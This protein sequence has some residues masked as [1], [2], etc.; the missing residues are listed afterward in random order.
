MA[1][2]LQPGDRV[3]L[4][5]H[6]AKWLLAGQHSQE[7]VMGWE[8]EVIAVWPQCV[9]GM[10]RGRLFIMPPDELELAEA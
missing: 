8:G 9:S 3:R 5:D 4:A 2:K 10:Y 1:K 7:D 6:V